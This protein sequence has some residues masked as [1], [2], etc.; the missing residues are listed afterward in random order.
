MVIKEQYL[1]CFLNFVKDYY[2]EILE[3]EPDFPSL[4]SRRGSLLSIRYFVVRVSF[5]PL[6]LGVLA[7]LEN[8]YDIR[9]CE[10]NITQIT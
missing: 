9:S 1:T 2:N 6:W 3:I 10:Y 5:T 4:F 8:V 7:F